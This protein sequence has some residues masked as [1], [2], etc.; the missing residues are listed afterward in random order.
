MIGR[1]SVS[2]NY[3]RNWYSTLNTIQGTCKKQYSEK[4]AKD[5]LDEHQISWRESEAQYGH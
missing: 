1:K 4:N 2:K 5:D 3:P